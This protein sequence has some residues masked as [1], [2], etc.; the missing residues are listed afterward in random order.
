VV[1]LH[2][3][4]VGR[5]VHPQVAGSQLGTSELESQRRAKVGV[6]V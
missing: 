1:E 4:P 3:L 6:D 5:Q 2:D